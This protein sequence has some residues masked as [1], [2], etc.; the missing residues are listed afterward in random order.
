MFTDDHIKEL[1]RLLGTT[2]QE[3]AH[4]YRRWLRIRMHI[5][6]IGNWNGADLI[7]PLGVHQ[8]NLQWRCDRRRAR[9]AQQ[10][11]LD[12]M[13]EVAVENAST[14]LRRDTEATDSNDHYA[15][16]AAGPSS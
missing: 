6:W 8:R 7:I 3:A 2:T 15:T 10:S 12:T 14:E 4:K 9:E 13:E 16:L 1:L 5:W 11:D